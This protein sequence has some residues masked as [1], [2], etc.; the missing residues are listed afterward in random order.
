VF[1]FHYFA[2]LSQVDIARLLDLTPKHVSR[3]WL[4]A[5]TRLAR[6]LDG[7]EELLT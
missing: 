3:L 7:I 5:T 2:D 6:R 1:D 4:A